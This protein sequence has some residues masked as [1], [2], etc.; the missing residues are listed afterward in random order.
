MNFFTNF[1]T[2]KETVPYFRFNSTWNVNRLDYPNP[3]TDAASYFHKD[4]NLRLR[5]L[6][7]YRVSFYG[8]ARNN[9]I[10]TSYDHIG[11]NII[12][13]YLTSN[14]YQSVNHLP[15][16]DLGYYHYVDIAN[17]FHIFQIVCYL[18]DS[19]HSYL[20]LKDPIVPCEEIHLQIAV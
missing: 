9:L 17:R 2:K 15:L 18:K 10:F 12:T 1:F 14:H 7:E 3:Y 19:F 5:I 13:Q 8:L 16:G 11:S 4:T 20:L 6:F